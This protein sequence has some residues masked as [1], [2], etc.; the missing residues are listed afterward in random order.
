[1]EIKWNKNNKNTHPKEREQR[2]TEMMEQIKN[3]QQ[4]S[5]LKPKS[6]DN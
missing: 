5:G 6:L 4:D 1:M 2:N 3:E